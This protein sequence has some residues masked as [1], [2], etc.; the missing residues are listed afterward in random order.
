V[1]WGREEQLRRLGEKERSDWVKRQSQWLFSQSCFGACQFPLHHRRSRKSS[2]LLSS[3]RTTIPS[4]RL[5]RRRHHHHHFIQGQPVRVLPLFTGV[6]VPIS[7]AWFR[8]SYFSR[9]V[10]A[11]SLRITDLGLWFFHTNRSCA[12]LHHIFANTI[13]RRPLNSPPR[14]FTIASLYHPILNSP[15]FDMAS[16][17]AVP[18]TEV[19]VKVPLPADGAP[20]SLAEPAS[21]PVAEMSGALPAEQSTEPKPVET[22]GILYTANALHESS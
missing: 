6:G 5:S 16:E 2:L 10:T 9:R 19:P 1:S 17:D 8:A 4:H 3:R 20:P 18:M 22:K 12:H 11:P 21:G 13:V 15:R 7:R 14:A